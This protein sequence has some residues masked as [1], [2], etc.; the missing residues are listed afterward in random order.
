M[1]FGETVRTLTKNGLIDTALVLDSATGSRRLGHVWVQPLEG[2]R[3]AWRTRAVREHRSA[4]QAAVVTVPRRPLTA[5]AGV[6]IMA[7]RA[8]DL[9]RYT[10][11]LLP[12]GLGQGRGQFPVS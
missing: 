3:K 6:A 8:A 2:A 5:A 7:G 12:G 1:S 10:A 11:R 4:G 9:H